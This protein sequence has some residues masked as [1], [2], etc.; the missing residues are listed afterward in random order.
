MSYQINFEPLQHKFFLKK[1]NIILIHF[2]GNKFRYKLMSSWK[3]LVVRFAVVILKS[4]WT[5]SCMLDVLLW[6]HNSSFYFLYFIYS[7][8]LQE[9]LGEDYRRALFASWNK[10]FKGKEVKGSQEFTQIRWLAPW[11]SLSRIHFFILISFIFVSKS[12]ISG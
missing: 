6:S 11:N 12:W 3:P 1:Y 7:R 5:N 10:F 2:L 4:C 8:L 9:Y